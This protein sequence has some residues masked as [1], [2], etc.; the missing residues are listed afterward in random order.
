[1]LKLFALVVKLI[2]CPMIILLKPG[3]VIN[4]VQS[5]ENMRGL[6]LPF[7]KRSKVEANMKYLEDDPELVI[8]NGLVINKRTFRNKVY[9]DWCKLRVLGGQ[10]FKKHVFDKTVYTMGLNKMME[11]LNE[12]LRRFEFKRKGNAGARKTK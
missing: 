1:M 11:Y 9:K 8:I 5:K 12:E 4:A 6:T 3:V 7:K 10:K 2:Q